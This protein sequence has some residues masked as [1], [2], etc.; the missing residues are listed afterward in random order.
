MATVLRLQHTSVPMPPDGHARARAFYGEALGMR[1][2]APPKELDLLNLVWFLAGDDGHEIHLFA[3][4]GLAAMSVAQHLCLQ[5]DDIDGIRARLQNHRI[6]VEETIA[7]P[8]RPRFFV[9][10]PFGNFIEIVQITGDYT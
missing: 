6:A 2:V 9:H 3:D 5:V 7:I 4:P 10:D 1:E 8:S